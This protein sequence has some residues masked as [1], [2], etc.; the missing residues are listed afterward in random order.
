MAEVT[1]VVATYGDKEWSE[2]A[3]RRALPS[4]Y[5]L[6]VPTIAI[7]GDTLHGARNAGLEDVT[8]Q[9]VCFLDAD[10][11]LE[12]GYF[13]QIATSEADLRVPRVRY[14]R[15]RRGTLMMPKVAGHT[16]DCTAECLAYGNW[17]VIG[18]VAPTELVK[19]VGGFRDFP[20]S[21]DWDLWVR[22]WHASATIEAVPSAVYRAHVRSDSRN[23]GAGQ[24]TKNAAHRAI[25]HANGLLSP[26]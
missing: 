17:M 6:R 26:V 24:A 19:K 8:T 14:M 13:D 4:A 22:C 3:D 15:G 20:W 21:E 1:V 11:A 2:L 16:H 10:D 7:H 9:Y 12:G 5:A 25:A 23:R 18:T